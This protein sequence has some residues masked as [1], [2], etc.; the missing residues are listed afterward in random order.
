MSFS[1]LVCIKAVPDLASGSE[2]VIAGRWI[3]EAAMAWCMNPYDAHALEAALAIKD[4]TAEVRV[5]AISAGPDRIRDT[6]RRAMAMGADAGIHLDMDAGGRLAP[7]TTAL[8]IARYAGRKNY[9]LILTGAMS[10]DEM[11][12]ITGPMIAAALDLPCAAAAIDFTPN[13]TSR[14]FRVTCEMEGGMAEIIRLSGPALVTVQTGRNA[15]RYPS[16]S[17]TLRSRRQAIERVV[18]SEPF[19]HNTPLVET[20]CVAYA[21]R[22]PTCQIIE[23][24]MHEKADQ[25]L[26][27]F[28][29]HGWLK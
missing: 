9:D 25:L 23:G 26:R 28:N 1:I 4:A 3:D 21:Q 15:P 29:D 14:S 8:A 27:L 24:T 19:D 11:N 17:N 6:L 2:L 20:V 5:D 16:L 10:E 13:L 18:P 12:G 22:A 7:Q